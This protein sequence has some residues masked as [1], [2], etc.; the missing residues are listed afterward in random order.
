MTSDIEPYERRRYERFQ[1]ESGAFVVPKAQKRRIWQIIDISRGGLA[2]RYIP[3]GEEIMEFSELEILT[4][5]TRFSLEKIP[6]RSISERDIPEER[7]SDYQ[8]KRHS[9]QFGDLTDNQISRL[10]HFIRNHAVSELRSSDYPA[11]H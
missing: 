7:I 2:F 6:Y 11:Y 3:L 8:L 9:V 10:E 4:R 1:A 5:D